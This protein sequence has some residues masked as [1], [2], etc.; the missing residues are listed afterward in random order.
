MITPSIEKYKGKIQE[1]V[2]KRKAVDKLEADLS[3]R[4]IDLETKT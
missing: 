3:K 4:F 2:D 1:I